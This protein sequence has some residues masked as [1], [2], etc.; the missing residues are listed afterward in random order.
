MADGMDRRTFL[1][2]AAGAAL[3]EGDTGRVVP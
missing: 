2:S 3:T 1:E